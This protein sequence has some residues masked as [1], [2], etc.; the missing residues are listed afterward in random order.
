MKII[1]IPLIVTIFFSLISCSQNIEKE[2]LYGTWERTESNDKNIELNI[3]S[4]GLILSD[5][6]KIKDE[7]LKNE[8]PEID[9]ALKKEYFRIDSLTFTRYFYGFGKTFNYEFKDNFIHIDGNKGYS[10]INVSSVELKLKGSEVMRFKRV[11]I[12][13]SDYKVSEK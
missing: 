11:N 12:D 7:K 2:Q 13:L 3:E 5:G 9:E 1:H 4:N 6:E 8:L 10:I